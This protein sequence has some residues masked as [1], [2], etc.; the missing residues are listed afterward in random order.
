MS[1]KKEVYAFAVKFYTVESYRETYLPQLHPI[2]RKIELK[3]AAEALV[4][5]EIQVV[6]PPKF[7]RPPGRPE[8]K[9]I[10]VD[11]LN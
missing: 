4:N 11:D 8:K 7:R 2:L 9:R 3:R 5:D 6:R 10:C 1:C